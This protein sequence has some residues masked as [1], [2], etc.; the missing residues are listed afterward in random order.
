M[1]SELVNWPYRPH[2]FGSKNINFFSI[3][4][5]ST[6]SIST[7]A[8]IGQIV[9]FKLNLTEL[10]W[11]TD[12]LDH[13]V[14]AWNNTSYPILNLENGSV[15]SICYG[16]LTFLGSVRCSDFNVSVIET[17]VVLIQ[18]RVVTKAMAADYIFYSFCTETLQIGSVHISVH[19]KGKD[20]LLVW[21][22]LESVR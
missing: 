21:F 9:N 17:N 14:L 19:L 7:V 8:R 12:H 15:H 16:N 2:S 11:C 18:M 13:S 20:S 22:Q 1:P 3:P 6:T 10:G 4:A 5:L